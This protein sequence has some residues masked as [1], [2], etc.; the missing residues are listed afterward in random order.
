MPKSRLRARPRR[1]ELPKDGGQCHAVSP[2]I[3]DRSFAA[4]T[5][6]QKWIADFTYIRTAQGWL[7]VAAVVDL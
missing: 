2:N 1:R 7:Y 5:P 4:S 6:N 3:L